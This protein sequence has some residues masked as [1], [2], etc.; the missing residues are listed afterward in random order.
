[1]E[2]LSMKRYE[3]PPPPPGKLMDITAW[4]ECLENSFAQLEHQATRIANLELML[5]CGAEG[6]KSYLT[7]LNRMVQ[8]AQTQHQN[9]KRDIQELNWNR[10]SGQL[11][12]GEELQ[13]LQN[14]WVALV[15]KNYEL[16]LACQAKELI[17]YQKSAELAQLK[18]ILSDVESERSGS[19]IRRRVRRFFLQ[20]PQETE[21]SSGPALNGNGIASENNDEEDEEMEAEPGSPE[22]DE[23]AQS[24]S[25]TNYTEAIQF[26]VDGSEA[27]VGQ[28]EGKSESEE[29]EESDDDDRN[30]PPSAGQDVDDD[31]RNPPPSAGQ[32]EDEIGPQPVP[33]YYPDSDKIENDPERSNSESGSN[34]NS[35]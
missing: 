34:S 29:S 20:Q 35:N 5:D 17:K 3:L 31:D 22:Q 26:E 14:S 28:E 11:K 7:V 8:Q 9:L 23:E 13:R 19:R 2:T 16:E 33:Q 4:T 6:W 18:F 12:A 10:K 21:D 30:P 25:G 15:S 32:D 24:A 1:M 27:Q